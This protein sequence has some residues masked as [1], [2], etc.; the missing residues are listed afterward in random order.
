MTLPEFRSSTPD[1]TSLAT[2][3]SYWD[4]ATECTVVYAS[5]TVE[6]DLW[7]DYVSGACESYQKHGVAAALDMD[8]LRRGHDTVLFAACVNTSG[9]VVA[10]LRARG[11]YG[12]ADECHAVREWD[13]QVG[14]DAVHKMVADRIPFGVAEMKT[15]WVTDDPAESRRL[16]TAIARTP[17]HAMTLL[18]IQFIVA[19]AASYVLK[20]WLSSGGV[21]ASKIPATPYPDARYDTKLAWWDRVNFAKHAEPAQVSAF[22]AEQRQMAVTIGAVST[23]AASHASTR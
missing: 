10:G 21:L 15:A 5:P 23:P 9:R 11:P 8:A 4:A 1:F 6:R 12:S 7:K 22:Y 20:R 18:D 13:G 3:P 16:T 17:L 14:Q 19:T 2:T